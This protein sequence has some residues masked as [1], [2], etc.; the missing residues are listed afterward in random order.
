MILLR[1][2]KVSN[3][4]L[5]VLEEITVQEG[6]K[7]IH[8]T[9]FLVEGKEGEFSV[10]T[11]SLQG[12]WELTYGDIYCDSCGYSDIPFSERDLNAIYKI[13]NRFGLKNVCYKVEDDGVTR[14]DL[15]TIDSIPVDSYTN[16]IRIAIR[17]MEKY[18]RGVV[19]VKGTD[20][21]FNGD[22][23]IDSQVYSMIYPPA[24]EVTSSDRD[25]FMLYRRPKEEA[26]KIV[27]IFPERNIIVF[28]KDA[29]ELII[30]RIGIEGYKKA[31]LTNAFES[32]YTDVAGSYLPEDIKF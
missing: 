20:I 22:R 11:N 2:F 13:A 7:F 15:E 24:P 29:R 18:E 12:E 21:Y 25:H 14:V 9:K 6:R 19:E 4:A 17:F 23:F 1:H 31:Q 16:L 32:G 3:G 30:K 10:V 27:Y 26:S 28:G 5:E 8:K